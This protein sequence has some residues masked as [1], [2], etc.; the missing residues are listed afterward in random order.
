MPTL[1]VI[2]GPPGAGKTTL[3]HLLAR[4]IGC[5]A[6]CR[7]EIKEGMVHSAG[8]FNAAPSD[9]LTL[10]TLPTFFNVLQLLLTAN[11][12]EVD[13]SDG[14]RPGLDEIGAFVNVGR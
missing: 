13:T 1:V 9:E 14:Y 4:R 11:E 2:S 12:I 8:D 6:I 3:A 10:R 7:D 5:P